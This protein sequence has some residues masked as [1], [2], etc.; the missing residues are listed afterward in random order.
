MVLVW[1]Y[2]RCISVAIER[3]ISTPALLPSTEAVKFDVEDDDESWTDAAE[4][5]TNCAELPAGAETR[6]RSKPAWLGQP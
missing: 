4:H 3:H 1:I 5:A 2:Y 6:I